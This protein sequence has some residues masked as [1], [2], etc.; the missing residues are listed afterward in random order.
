MTERYIP[1]RAILEAALMETDAARA[2]WRKTRNAEGWR[3]KPKFAL[4]KHD[5]FDAT[6]LLCCSRRSPQLACAAP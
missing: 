5:S 3:F 1:A 6:G 4:G 2:E